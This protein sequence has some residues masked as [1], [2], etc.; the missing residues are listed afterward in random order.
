MKIF[1]SKDM[2]LEHVDQGI[3]KKVLAYDN[4]LMIVEVNFDSGSIGEVHHHEH[5][6]IVYVKTGEF[7][8]NVDG[9]Y[10][11]LDIGDSV[12]IPGNVPHGIKCINAGIILDVFTPMRKDFLNQK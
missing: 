11:K 4:N 1:K 8:F 7:E 3:N 12:Y 6:Q 9:V 2:I 10:T 5:E